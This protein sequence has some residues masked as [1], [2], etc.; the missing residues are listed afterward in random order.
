M[1]TPGSYPR[2]AVTG[3]ILAGGRGTRMGGAD[4]GLV[5]VA[6]RPMVEH[7]LAAVAPQA[8]T[9]LINANRSAEHYARYGCPV[10]SD[11]LDGFQGPLAGMASALESAS[12]E[13]VLVVPC[14]SPLV[15][16]TLGPRLHA[17]LVAGSTNVAVAHDGERMHPVFVLLRRS[18]LPGLAEFLARGERKIDRWFA[19]E[20]TAVVDFSD[21]PDMFLNVNRD[22]DRARLESRLAPRRTDRPEIGSGTGRTRAGVVSGEMPEGEAGAGRGGDRHAGRA[23]RTDS[24]AREEPGIVGRARAADETTEGAGSDRE[25]R[26]PAPDRS[27][28]RRPPVVGLAG[29][30][31]SGKTTLATSVVRALAAAGVRV[32]AVKHAHHSF[33]VDR[34][35][36]DSYELRRA[37]AVQTLVG[38]RDRLALVTERRS[39]REPTLEELV[40]QIDW[41]AVDIVL[42]EGFKHAEF[43]KI[44]VGRGKSSA[45][46]DDAFVVAVA[47]P[48]GAG[49]TSPRARTLPRLD[50]DRPD[51]VASFIVERFL[52]P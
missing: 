28:V 39:P 20:T 3:A 44:A 18:V 23:P 21:L 14:D 2:E 1:N 31:G 43:P 22:A 33:D 37:G 15:A 27:P 50:L 13:F 11:R 24:E 51:Q 12:T 38:S 36:K 40:D 41:S 25:G 26:T 4:K 46:V 42:V 30:S 8:G 45:M 34:P 7:V 5:E 19:E 48:G 52:T 16:P 9:V 49:G 17:A 29:Y 35:G 6:G 10:I 32:A 47:T